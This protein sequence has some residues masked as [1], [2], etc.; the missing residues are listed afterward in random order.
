MF[1]NVIP[2]GTDFSPTVKF[3]LNGLP[4]A[5]E[6]LALSGYG[7]SLTGASVT[8]PAAVMSILDVCPDGTFSG[9]GPVGCSTT[10]EALVVVNTEGF[11]QTG[12]VRTGTFARIFDIFTEITLDQG[13]GGTASLTLATVTI[14]AVPEPATALLIPA[15]F[16][17]LALLRRRSSKACQRAALLSRRQP[18]R[19]CR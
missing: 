13:T 19:L 9:P 16:G 4:L 2:G 7:I 1:V 6:S 5:F 3:A 15:A 8:D 11:P 12:D 18:S 10:P 14:N 17:L